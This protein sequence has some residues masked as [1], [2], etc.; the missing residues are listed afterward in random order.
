VRLAARGLL[1]LVFFISYA[2]VLRA[3]TIQIKL[4]DGKTGR[5]AAGACVGACARPF[6]G[7]LPIV[8]EEEPTSGEWVEGILFGLTSRGIA[9]S[10][11]QYC[12]IGSIS[13][14]LPASLEID[15]PREFSGAAGSSAF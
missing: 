12:Q 13:E 9:V 8:I 2:V 4:V 3:Q 15:T 14:A 5:P 10:P 7:C 1:A 11:R 6:Q